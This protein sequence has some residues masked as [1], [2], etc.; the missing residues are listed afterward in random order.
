MSGDYEDPLDVWITRFRNLGLR[1]AL[2]MMDEH[3]IIN[4]GMRNR[5]NELEGLG[6]CYEWLPQE[7]LIR[8]RVAQYRSS[9]RNGQRM[10]VLY[11]TAASKHLR[12][13]TR[14]ASNR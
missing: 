6:I 14:L 5:P 2:T 7:A 4:G 8:R 9:L 10:M 11:F 13:A 3:L 1:I 12:R